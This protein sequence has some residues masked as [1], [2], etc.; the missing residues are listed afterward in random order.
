MA[1]PR[2]DF[3]KRTTRQTDLKKMGH[4]SND[5]EEFLTPKGKKPS[6]SSTSAMLLGEILAEIQNQTRA[7][8]ANFNQLNS[9]VDKLIECQESNKRT[10]N[11]ETKEKESDIISSQSKSKYWTETLAKRTRLYNNFW[12]NSSKAEIYQQYLSLDPIFIPKICKEKEVLGQTS[13]EWKALQ[14]E[15]EI[16]NIKHSIQKM[17]TFAQQAKDKLEELDKN[18]IDT[19]TDLPTETKQKIEDTW[20][21]DVKNSEDNA[22]VHWSLNKD[23]LEKLPFKPK[24]EN[25]DITRDKRKDTT[26]MWRHSNTTSSQVRRGGEVRSSSKPFRTPMYRDNKTPKFIPFSETNNYKNN[27]NKQNFQNRRSRTRSN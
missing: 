1:E 2:T 26:K 15:R 11:V 6:T 27:N 5:Q 17:R 20:R 12:K 18:F 19:F 14:D 25:E 9:K 10:V 7:L 22:K 3:S 4:G 16:S 13:D 21:F 24:K 8:E 23:F